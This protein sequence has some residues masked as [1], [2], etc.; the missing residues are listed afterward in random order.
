[1]NDLRHQ[2]KV[3]CPA[4]PAPH[5]HR[6]ALVSRVNDILTRHVAVTGSDAQPSPYKLLLLHAPA[7]YGKTTL[8]A[9]FAQQTHHLCCWYFLDQTDTDRMTFLTIL[10]LSIRQQFPD[11]GRMLDSLLTG[12][13]SEHANHPAT[14]NYFDMVVDILVSA[15]E[16]DIAERFVLLLCNYQEINELPDMN[17]MVNSLLSKLPRQCVLVIESRVIPHLDFAQLLTERMAF[18]LGVNQ[19]RFTATQIHQ[20]AQLQGVGPFTDAEAHQL[21]LTF[22]GWITGIL[23][24]T[25]LGDA[26][27]FQQNRL[28]PLFAD[29]PE[30]QVV[31]PY[32]FSYVV[33]EVFKNHQTAYTFLREACVL[34]EMPPVLCAKLLDISLS[35]ASTH[36]HYLE[37]QGLFVTHSGE[38][39]SLVYTC[40]S[41]LRKLFYEELRQD[42]PERFSQLHRRAAEL[43]SVS[44]NYRQ[45]IFHA[46]EASAHEI[47]V[48]LMIASAEQ[49]MNQGHAET[50][51]RWIDAFSTATTTR[52]P[53]LL[54]I[55]A[56]IYLRQGDHDA[57][58]P[59]LDTADTAVVQALTNQT[60]LLDIPNL[61]ALQAELAIVR[62]KV[63]YRQREYQQSQF[64]CQQVL[65]SLPADEVTLR[66]EAHMRLG[67]CYILLG[68][69]TAGIAQVQKALQ[70]WGRHTIQRQ[71]ADGH[72]VLA[73]AYALLGNFAL[74][75]HHMTRALACWDQLQD[76][77]GKIDNLVRLG[78][79]KVRQGMFP[80]AE[81]IFLD[82]LAQARG[83]IRYLRGQAYAL[84]CLGIFY[85]RQERY[86]RA[87]EVT[88]EALALARQLL[89]QSLIYD[90]LCDLAMIYLAMGDTATAMILI[91]EVQVQT[92]SGNSIGYEQVIRDLIYGAIYLSQHQYTQA[93]TYLSTSE[94]TL[95]QVGLKQEHLQAL[96]RLATCHLAQNQVPDAVHCLEVAV[97]IIPICEGYEQVAQ[98]EVRHLPRLQQAL[99]T[100]P[101]MAKVRALLHLEARFQMTPNPEGPPSLQEKQL[102]P[103]PVSPAP[104]LEPTVPSKLTILAFGEPAIY[105]QQE[106]V[107]RWRMAR[108]MELC[109]YLLDCARPVR[110]EAIITELWPKVDEQTVRTFYSTIYY[111]RQAL[112]GEA[113]IVA[114][115]GSYALRLE[116]LYGK[117]V[118]YDVATFENVQTLAKH[119]LD[120]EQDEEAKISYLAM[121]D[122]YRGDYVQPFYSDWC[123]NRRDELRNAYLNARHQLA[124]I[125]WRAEDLDESIVHWQHMLAVDNWL[126][127]AHYGLMRCYS[128]Q[129]KR[130]LAL[131]QYQRCKDTLEQEF[132]AAPKASIQNLYQ[133]LMGSL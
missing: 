73:R 20:L 127:E 19:L 14:L 66:A 26:Q 115:G 44:N 48:R 49:M 15:I 68:D 47:A 36:L 79:I 25:R 50:L 118:C 122:L 34:Q 61:P 37:Q 28:A 124:L 125:T 88:E 42:T 91:S 18:G 75:E 31:S 6:E 81:T 100:L 8:L 70:L 101:E 110:K 57:A 111:L 55:R 85:Q 83:P 24:G 130:G 119:A 132:G 76:N 77:W 129:G 64:L 39:S 12:A 5:V 16:T 43:L 69:F 27:Q 93:W 62:S 121:V 95:S 65:T 123:T 105:L 58:L 71:T 102:P 117:E 52:Y 98:L 87:L 11:F 63:L 84:D 86:E 32:L 128:R 22:D 30:S 126:E 106:L 109:F 131:R 3:T 56:N 103:Q 67:L 9:D 40:S 133:R 29:V 114:K 120:N 72:S 1:M 82:A 112:G 92:M 60:S 116:V 113:V 17:T 107:S 74:A 59:L 51:A 90:T 10:L 78:N 33:N 54:L 23:L 46:L 38:G 89:D 41:V 35:Q 13:S 21:M 99:T 104:V 45:A 80:E 97:L 4:L 108:A 96:L 94:A 53:Q 2:R 7:G